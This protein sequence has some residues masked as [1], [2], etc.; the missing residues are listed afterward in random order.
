MMVKT[1]VNML[2]DCFSTMILS[3]L[4]H[5][6]LSTWVYVRARSVPDPDLTF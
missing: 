6:V 1:V 4:M 3:S 5:K 2:L